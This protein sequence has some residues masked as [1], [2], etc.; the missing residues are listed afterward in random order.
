MKVK[1]SNCSFL[2]DNKGM[3]GLMSGHQLLHFYTKRHCFTSLSKCLPLPIP[4]RL[5]VLSLQR[6]FVI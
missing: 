1:V 4:W 2:K 6:C 5:S 3:Q